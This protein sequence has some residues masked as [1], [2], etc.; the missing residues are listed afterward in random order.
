MLL[1]MGGFEQSK[2]MRGTAKRV[3]AVFDGKNKESGVLYSQSR[4]VNIYVE[5]GM[6]S[7]LQCIKLRGC[8]RVKTLGC[9]FFAIGTFDSPI[10]VTSCSGPRD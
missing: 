2:E 3:D 9:V 5:G 8:E 6:C 7:M 4:V 1:R 10:I